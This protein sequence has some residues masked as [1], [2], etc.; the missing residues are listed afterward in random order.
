MRHLSEEA[1]ADALEGRAAVGPRAHLRECAE[2]AARLAEA[3]AGLALARGSDV[4]EPP[5]EYWVELRRSVGRR[6]AEPQPEARRPVIRWL[7]PLAAAAAVLV[8]AFELRTPSRSPEPVATAAASRAALPAWSALPPLDEDE[9]VPL[10]EGVLVSTGTA[11]WDEG[12]GPEAYVAGL[13][14][15]ESSS[16][17]AAL[18]ASAASRRSAGGERL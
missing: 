17:A 16:L 13:N 11:G 18:A 6:I 2:C 12:R 4:P 5:A 15:D 1:F 14:D 7:V 10:L 8:A 9:A 3:E